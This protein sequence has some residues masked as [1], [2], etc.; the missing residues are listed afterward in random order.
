MELSLQDAAARSGQSLRQLRY[1]I[2]QGKLAARKVGGRW[3]IDEALLGPREGPALVA[4]AV[5]AVAPS[6]AL[7]PATRQRYSLNDL[8]AFKIGRP[9]YAE[10]V[11][12][13]GGDTQAARSLRNCLDALAIGCHRFAPEEKV[14]AYREARDAASRAV[15]ALLIA[16]ED[17][18]NALAARIEQDLMAALAGLLRRLER[19]RR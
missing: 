15:A 10:L 13:G 9:L 7:V 5:A 12:Q 17:T 4:A 16:G 18:S 3:V 19:R 8:V 2:A 6:A 1:A 14:A 11:A